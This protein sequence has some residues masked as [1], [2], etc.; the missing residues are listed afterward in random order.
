MIPAAQIVEDLRAGGYAGLI[1]A[2]VA[3]ST[4]TAVAVWDAEA[5]GQDTTDG[6]WAVVCESHGAILNRKTRAAAVHFAPFP[7]NFCEDCAALS[8]PIQDTIQE[9]GSR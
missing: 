3:R 5:Q 4:G 9:G 8:E 6:R 1:Q 2:R 7:A